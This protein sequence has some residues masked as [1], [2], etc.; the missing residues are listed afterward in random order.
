M[1]NHWLLNLHSLFEVV[2]AKLGVDSKWLMKIIFLVSCL[3]L[4]RLCDYLC[5]GIWTFNAKLRE[6]IVR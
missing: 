4:F 1:F 2:L 6:C 5:L 3:L